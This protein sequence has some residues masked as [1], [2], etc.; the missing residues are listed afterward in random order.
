Y[1]FLFDPRSTVI[2]KN[3]RIRVAYLDSGAWKELPAAA[4][5]A[6]PKHLRRF[7]QQPTLAADDAGHIYMTFRCRT[8]AATARVDYWA[9]NGRWN[10]FVTHLDGGQWTRAV[11]MPMSDGRNGMFPAI[12]M[13]AGN[14]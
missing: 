11:E 4:E 7:L 12:A 1:T 5:E 14:A 9:N 10:T 6:M 2:Y 3:R 8:S 13:H